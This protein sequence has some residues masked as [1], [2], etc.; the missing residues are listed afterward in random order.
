MFQSV[1]HDDG[2]ILME[3]ADPLL[4]LVS[5]PLVPV[6]LVLGKMIRWEDAVSPEK[7]SA[8]MGVL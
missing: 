6:G 1:G 4:L 3:R 7:F 5:L 8:E 2:L